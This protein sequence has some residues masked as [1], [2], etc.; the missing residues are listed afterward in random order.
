M[1]NLF[2]V[3]HELFRCC[4]RVVSL[5]LYFL[6]VYNKV[7]ATPQTPFLNVVNSAKENLCKDVINI[8]L[9]GILFHSLFF[10]WIM[11]EKYWSTMDRHFREEERTLGNVQTTSFR[12]SIQYLGINDLNW[13]KLNVC[14][15]NTKFVQKFPTSFLFV[16]FNRNYVLY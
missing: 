8:L 10:P 3:L 13:V 5:A 7:W 11:L 6:R 9:H 14:S 2:S 16:L 1:F 15:I 12:K 4:F